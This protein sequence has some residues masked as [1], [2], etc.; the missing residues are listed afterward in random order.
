MSKLNFL[1]NIN[2][3][4]PILNYQQIHDQNIIIIKNTNAFVSFQ[5]LKLNI[6]CLFTLLNYI[7]GVDLLNKNYRFCIVYDLLSLT[8]NSRLRIKIFLNETMFAFSLFNIYINSN[9]WEREIWDLYGIYF[10]QHPD[11]RRILTDYGFEGHPMRKDFPIYGYVEVRY[12]ETK[13]RVLIEPINL[14]QEFR[15]FNFETPW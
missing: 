4:I 14:S 9:W 7:A 13:K 2:K 11:L 8:Y 5:F 15:V 6:G 1:K 10:D 12:D 3:I